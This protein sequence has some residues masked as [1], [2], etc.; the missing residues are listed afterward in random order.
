[1]RILVNI[2]VSI[3]ITAIVLVG[4]FYLHFRI[5]PTNFII[6]AAIVLGLHLAGLIL[7]YLIFKQG[8]TLIIVYVTMFVLLIFGPGFFTLDESV[9]SKLMSK[10]KWIRYISTLSVSYIIL[11]ITVAASY[12]Y[13]FIKHKND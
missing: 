12:R 1:M 11:C 9:L 8:A 2:V 3:F 6:I 10:A 4:A 7:I 5:L 13:Y